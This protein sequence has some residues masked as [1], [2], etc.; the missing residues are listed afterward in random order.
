MRNEMPFGIP[1]TGL[2]AGSFGRDVRNS[3][4]TSAITLDGERVAVGI[5]EPG[6]LAAASPR[7]DAL[8]VVVRPV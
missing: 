2:D 6:D 4:C 7:R 5:L 8:V 3:S 1:V